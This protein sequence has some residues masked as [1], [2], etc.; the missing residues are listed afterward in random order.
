MYLHIDIDIYDIFYE[1][2]QKT[3]YDGHVNGGNPAW[4]ISSQ[5]LFK[6]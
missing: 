2:R 6:V 5:A 1:T 4:P 3:Y